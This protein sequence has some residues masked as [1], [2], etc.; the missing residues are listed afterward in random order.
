MDLL[1]TTI[2]LCLD[3]FPWAKFRQ[4]KG[5]VKAHVLLDHDDYLPSYHRSQDKRCPR[6]P[7]PASQ[8]RFHCGD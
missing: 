2:S 7:V 5:G 8:R 1:Y 3:L 6:G 4:A